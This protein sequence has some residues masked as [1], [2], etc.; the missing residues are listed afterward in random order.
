MIEDALSNKTEERREGK[1]KKTSR[2]KERVQL[3]TRPSYERKYRECRS[4]S[5]KS[6]GSDKHVVYE[7]VV[8]VVSIAQTLCA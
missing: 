3:E 7:Q 1:R 4:V 8:L 6:V 2:M 5:N